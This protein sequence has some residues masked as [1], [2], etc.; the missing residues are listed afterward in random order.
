MN[1]IPSLLLILGMAWLPLS[2]A[3]DPF[4]GS[5][6]LICS[7]DDSVDCEDDENYCNLGDATNVNLP[8]LI[9]LDFK[10]KR[11]QPLGAASESEGA[12]IRN[13]VKEDGRLI[14]QGAQNGRGW[15]LVITRDV[16]AATVAIAGG[17][18]GFLIFGN[19]TPD[20]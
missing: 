15:S 9:R 10:K 14:L 20:D 4:D 7:L 17:A 13:V 16:G 12:A 18:H 5:K 3:A 19:C 1:R 11:V 2:A 8:A 6:P